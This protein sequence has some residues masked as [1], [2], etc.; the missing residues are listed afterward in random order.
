MTE[1]DTSEGQLE[2]VV[3]AGADTGKQLT[4]WRRR[5]VG[6]LLAALSAH[7]YTLAI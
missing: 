5:Y 3:A 7:M 1:T 6:T 4:P 2:P